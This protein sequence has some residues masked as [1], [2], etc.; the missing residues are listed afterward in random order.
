[1]SAIPTPPLPTTHP[2]SASSSVVPPR[3]H[4]SHISP[5]PPGRT[6]SKDAVSTY[7]DMM[8]LA[9]I[10]PDQFAFPAILKAVMGL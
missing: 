8:A 5:S 3:H 7:A 2:V 9:S 4:P 1:M 10:P 6:F